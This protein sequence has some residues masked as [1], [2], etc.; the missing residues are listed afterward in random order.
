MF[1]DDL[2]HRRIPRPEQTL[3]PKPDSPAAISHHRRQTDT[4]PLMV[5]REEVE[6]GS[7]ENGFA[8][9]WLFA[10]LKSAIS[11]NPSNRRQMSYTDAVNV[12]LRHNTDGDIMRWQVTPGSA[13]CH[14]DRY[15]DCLS[16]ELSKHPLVC[17][18]DLRVLKHMYWNTYCIMKTSFT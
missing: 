6:C 2:F 5:L 14:G 10:H 3:P 7:E 17:W 16:Y 1:T 15:F 11:Q 9:K 12:A 18:L 13:S 4:V 8:D